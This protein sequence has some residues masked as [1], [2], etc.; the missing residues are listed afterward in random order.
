MRG[1]QKNGFQSW[2]N[3][4][5]FIAMVG[6][7]HGKVGLHGSLSVLAECL[8]M[9]KRVNS[10]HVIVSELNRFDPRSEVFGNVN[11]TE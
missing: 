8:H 6:I 5:V 9:F 7:H 10:P 2:P 11:I 3:C 4:A 1:I